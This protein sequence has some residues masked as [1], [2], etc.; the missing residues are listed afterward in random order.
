M[1]IADA[2]GDISQHTVVEI[3]PGRGAIT[4]HLAS[5]ARR[6]VAVELDTDLAAD[7]RQ[8]FADQPSVEILEQD[9][10]T[11][12]LASLVQHPGEKLMVIG[13]LPYYITSDILLH[14][15]DQS[16]VLSRVVLMVQREVADRVAASPGNR[17][18][19]LLSTTVQLFARVDK[20][21][22][23]PPDAFAPP[24]DVYSTVFRMTLAPRCEELGVEAEEFIQLLRQ[25][26]AQKRKML[27][28]NLKAAGY[29]QPAIL[30]AFD[31]SGIDPQAR[32]E[33]LS[34]ESLARLHHALRL[35]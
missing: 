27:A 14:L 1:Q 13:N 33:A 6:L 18:Y 26:F 22:T 19:G 21:F 17:D 9:I 12:D 28:N 20:L 35:H 34:L 2:L 10:L 7:L 31:K 8:S 32:A 5:R 16:A 4:H 24:P 30:E 3:G 29:E 23:L 11:L 15:L 25:S